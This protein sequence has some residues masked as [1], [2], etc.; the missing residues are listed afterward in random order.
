MIRRPEGALLTSLISFEDIAGVDF[1][2]DVVEA[3]VVAV[4][5]DSLAL[6]FEFG[7]VVDDEAA[8]EGGAVLEGGLTSSAIGYV[9]A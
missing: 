7:E 2:L 8:K 4:S 1:L 3:G 9:M 5:D 6:G